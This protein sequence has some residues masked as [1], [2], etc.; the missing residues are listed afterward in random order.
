MAERQKCS[1]YMLR[2]A[3]AFLR[4]VKPFYRLN[5]LKMSTF[6]EVKPPSNAGMTVLERDKFVTHVSL[7]GVKL[8]A[9]LCSAAL[10]ALKG[11]VLD[12]P[13]QVGCNYL[14]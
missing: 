11:S 2:L 8:P 14:I 7:I 13:R 5:H 3:A 12:I 1:I 4:H 6:A 10:T 9:K